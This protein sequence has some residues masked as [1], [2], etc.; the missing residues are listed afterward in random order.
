MGQR[1]VLDQQGCDGS[2]TLL[3]TCFEDGSL[4]MAVGHGLVLRHLSEEADVAQEVI[5]PVAI[6]PALETCSLVP[7]FVNVTPDTAI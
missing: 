1:A 2:A 5:Q 4:G 3:Y 6:G 7:L